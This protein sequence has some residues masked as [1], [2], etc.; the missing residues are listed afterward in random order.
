MHTPKKGAGGEVT[1]VTNTKA[2]EMETVSP[3]DEEGLS[4]VLASEPNPHLVSSEV[5]R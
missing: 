3:W 5:K 1:Q 2:L 4:M